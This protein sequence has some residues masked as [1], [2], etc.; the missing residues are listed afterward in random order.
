MIKKIRKLPSNLKKVGSYADIL[1]LN[2]YLVGGAV[3]DL[4]MGKKSLDWDIVVEGNPSP[5]IEKLKKIWRCPAK[6]HSK[7]G[8]FV[9]TFSEKRHID[10]VT[11]RK[12][13]YPKP[14]ILPC[15]IFSNLKDDL[16][17]RDFTLNAIALGLNKKNMGTIIDYYGG[18]KDLKSRVL[19]ILHKK[20]FRDDPTRI[21]R[22]ARFS[23]RGFK[24]E[25]NT[26][27]LA[28][29]D[30]NYVNYISAERIREEILAILDEKN[31]YNALAL[32]NKWGVFSIVLPEIKL[33]PEMRKIRNLSGLP[34]RLNFLLSQL[35]SKKR[36]ELMERLKLTRDI[37]KKIDKLNKN[38]KTKAVL[39]GDDLIR[40]GYQPGP[41]FREILSKLSC[42]GFN[43]RQKALRFVIDN[44]PQK[45]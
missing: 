42:R 34:K 45:R 6:H 36:K 1:G 14:G 40:L 2:A 9:L 43:S 25:K 24:I 37:K 10:F 41:I 11:A 30:R 4:L 5:L 18:L 32:I 8:T 13:V 17:R 38:K 35:E 20:S 29:K 23:G 39:A 7:F 22:L 26:K 16:F 21:F 31:P 3:R 33:K 28:V 15:V 12:E 27:R 44:Y 19:R